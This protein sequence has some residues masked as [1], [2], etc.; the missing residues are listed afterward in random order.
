[1][2]HTAF[3][4]KS[5]HFSFRDCGLADPDFDSRQG[6][7]GVLYSPKP[8]DWFQEPLSLS[9]SGYQVLTRG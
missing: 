9:F 2:F 1:M 3:A 7:K 6:K 5:F 4:Q 8:L